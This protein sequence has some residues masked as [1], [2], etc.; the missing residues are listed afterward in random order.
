[1]LSMNTS[2]L[3]GTGPVEDTVAV[4]SARRVKHEDGTHSWR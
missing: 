1:M 4:P 2:I 3:S